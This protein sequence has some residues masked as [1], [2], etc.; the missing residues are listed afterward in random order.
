ML[1]IKIGDV[2]FDTDICIV[3]NQLPIV[4]RFRVLGVF[5]SCDVPSVHTPTLLHKLIN[6]RVQ[7]YA[8]FTCRDTRLL[9][10]AFLVYVRPFSLM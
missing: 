3:G 4:E 6:V 8:F 2:T 7:S 1:C 5:V 9:M 10:H